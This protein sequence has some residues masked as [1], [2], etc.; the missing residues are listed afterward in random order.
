MAMNTGTGIRTV[1]GFF[2]TAEQAN[3]AAAELERAGIARSSIRVISERDLAQYADVSGTG[4]LGRGTDA[5]TTAGT[6]AG[7]ALGSTPTFFSTA[8]IP[9]EDARYYAEGIRR[10]GVLLTVSTPEAE[11]DRAAEIMDRNGAIDIDERRGDW[12]RAEAGKTVPVVEERLRVG[13]RETGSRSVRVYTEVHEQPVEEQVNLREEHVRV[14]RRPVDRPANEADLSAFR[15]GTIELT[16]T[17]EVPVVAKEA[18]VVEEVIVNKDVTQRTET[19]RDTVRKTDV[20]IDYEQDERYAPAYKYGSTVAGDVRYRDTE[21]DKAEP[22]IRRDWES[23]GHGKWEEFKEAVR[24][25]WD[26]VRG[27]R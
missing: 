21:W 18:R 25:G 17:R 3:R 10:G 23:R 24:H 14:E 27:R 22:D 15:E 7:G 12:D 20:R 13:K 1:A 6:A 2:D 16:E 19:V 26:R 4:S 8:G 9:A 11:A 5:A